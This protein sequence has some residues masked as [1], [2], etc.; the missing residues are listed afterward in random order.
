MNVADL[1]SIV[2]ECNCDCA[3]II[4]VI[5]LDD[6]MRYRIVIRDLIETFK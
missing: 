6:Y 2:R 3:E 4:L 5:G 1:I